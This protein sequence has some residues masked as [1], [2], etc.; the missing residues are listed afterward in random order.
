MLSS[1]LM[2]LPEYR[3]VLFGGNGEV[4]SV[5]GIQAWI[6]KAWAEGFDVE[7]YHQLYPLVSSQS[8]IG[9][10]ECAALLRYFGVR[11]SVVDFGIELGCNSTRCDHFL[12]KK[13]APRGFVCDKCSFRISDGYSYFCSFCDF[14]LCPACYSK[15]GSAHSK[16]P[17]QHAQREKLTSRVSRALHTWLQ[18][19]FALDWTSFGAPSVRDLRAFLPPIYF[20]HEGHSRTIV[21]L[22]ETSESP[23]LLLFD[24]AGSGS[25]LEGHLRADLAGENGAAG[26]W[27]RLLKRGL[28]TLRM[29]TYQ[30]VYVKPG[31]MTEK[32]REES[33]LVISED[34]TLGAHFGCAST[35]TSLGSTGGMGSTS[36]VHVEVEGERE[37]KTDKEKVRM[38]RLAALGRNSS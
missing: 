1:S 33:K 22:D 19:Y 18:S 16:E 21:G 28:H 25:I 7:G 29:K 17:P 6:E 35:Q 37:A 15:A 5:H 30:L 34:F 26:S 36:L 2:Q 23:S 4:P 11:A 31:L 8:W 3:E 20:Q 38:K 13:S 24:P 27:Q 32:E 12:K 10:T 9:A 14:D